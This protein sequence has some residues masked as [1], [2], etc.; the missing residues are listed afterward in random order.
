MKHIIVGALGLFLAMGALWNQTFAQPNNWPQW[1]QNPQHQGSVDTVGQSLSSKLANIVYDPFVPQEQQDQ[2]GSLLAHY[3]ATLLQENDAYMMFKTGTYTLDDGTNT[4]TP[5]NSQIWTEKRLNWEA[6]QL[7][8][9][10][11]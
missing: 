9:R 7:A 8:E 11:S 3:Q 10:G 1:G 5:W 6:G 4:A 2:G